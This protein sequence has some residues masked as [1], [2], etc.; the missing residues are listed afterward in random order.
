MC[1]L[2]G[3]T[4]VYDSFFRPYVAK[5]ENDV[6]RNLLKLRTWARDVAVFYSQR[7][8]SYSQTR[9][10][11]ILQYI[12]AQ[13]TPQPRLAQELTICNCVVV[14]LYLFKHHILIVLSGLSI[15]SPYWLLLYDGS[16]LLEKAI[17][18]TLENCPSM[19][20]AALILVF[21]VQICV[22]FNYSSCHDFQSIRYL[23]LSDF[24][25]TQLITASAARPQGWWGTCCRKLPALEKSTSQDQGAATLSHIKQ[26]I[27]EP[28][29]IRKLENWAGPSNTSK[30]CWWWRPQPQ[31]A[32]KRD[33]HGGDP[34]SNSV[35]IAEGSV[36]SNPFRNQ[37]NSSL[38]RL[39]EQ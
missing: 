24:Y 23:F 39:L 30:A 34:P 33:S 3:T 27:I 22:A 19:T 18:W 32:S 26:H 38:I 28:K 37:G 6:D 10:F 15:E 25:L 17:S 4:Y 9:I 11:Q 29:T 8:V 21:I 35:Q 14:M 12:A 2:Q 1:Q 13:A 31:P 7:A 36:C 16:S 20:Y 5:H